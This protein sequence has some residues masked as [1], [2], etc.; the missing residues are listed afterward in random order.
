M[1][2]TS[3]KAVASRR[4]PCLPLQVSLCLYVAESFGLLK[5]R[6]AARQREPLERPTACTAQ[7]VTSLHAG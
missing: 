6:V 1:L 3:G 4:G 7:A 5:L 2:P